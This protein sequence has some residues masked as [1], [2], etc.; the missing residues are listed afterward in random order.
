MLSKR[1]YTT[2]EVAELLALPASTLRYWEGVFPM[3]KPNRTVRGQRRFTKA[4]VKMAA[5]IKELLYEKGLSSDAAIEMMN[6]TYN[7]SFPRKQPQCI[8]LRGAIRLLD[9]VKA[10]IIEDELA[11]A[12]IEAVIKFLSNEHRGA[13]E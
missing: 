10:T 3:F 12:K 8:A 5:K 6:K 9:E 4:D 13:N 11:V 1:F 2:T 7:K